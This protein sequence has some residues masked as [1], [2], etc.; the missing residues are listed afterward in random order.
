MCWP[1]RHTDAGPGS[2]RLSGCCMD[3]SRH[4]W[5][6]SSQA[7]CL[8]QVRGMRGSCACLRQRHDQLAELVVVHVIQAISLQGR[9][10]SFKPIAFGPQ[11][12]ILLCKVHRLL[13][14]PRHL[15]L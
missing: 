8:W 5:L 2:H 15:A 11:G 7:C 10:S 9:V 6:A 1:H 13:L 14:Q 12:C 3:C 4:A